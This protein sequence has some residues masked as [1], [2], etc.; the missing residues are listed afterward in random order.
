M[1]VLKV[2][3]HSLRILTQVTN[4]VN[5][6]ASNNDQY[7]RRNR[8]VYRGF[9]DARA[10]TSCEQPELKAYDGAFARGDCWN[11]LKTLPQYGH[12]CFFSVIF[13]YTLG[14]PGYNPSASLPSQNVTFSSLQDLPLICNSTKCAAMQ[15]LYHLQALYC[16][17]P[18]IY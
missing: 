7:C 13:M 12:C 9:V 1:C 3:P 10:T 16:M 6:N 18:Y 2:M 17:Y 4:L 11:Q 8:R 14:C 15:L 5:N